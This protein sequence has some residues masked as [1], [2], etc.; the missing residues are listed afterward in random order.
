MLWRPIRVVFLQIALQLL[1]IV[2][3]NYNFFNLLT[4]VLCLPML[5]DDDLDALGRLARCN[6]AR[7]RG[8]RATAIADAS[9]MAAA[10]PAAEAAAAAAKEPQS[11]QELAARLAEE[12]R[13]KREAC[14]RTM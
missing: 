9:V 14:L 12:R 3:G 6:C 1:I 5:D 4:I 13:A 10:A 7:R 8:D 11:V 2:T